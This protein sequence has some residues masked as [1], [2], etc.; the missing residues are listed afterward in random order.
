MRYQKGKEL[1]T[2]TLLL[3]NSAT[4]E[5]VGADRVNVKA[6]LKE[7]FRLELHNEIRKLATAEATVRTSGV[8]QYQGLEKVDGEFY[9]IRKNAKEYLGIRP[10]QPTT[11]SDTVRVLLQIA[12]IM[13]VY[14][15]Q[16]VVL[17]G[18]S[19]GQLQLSPAPA[20]KVLLQDPP[21]INHL[22]K[23]L[24]G[25]YEYS[26]PVEVIKGQAWGVKADV[27]SWGELA[28]R[29]LTGEA[30]FAAAQPE[31]RSAKVI[32]GMVIDP[33]NIQP[34]LS[35]A[36]SRLISACL[37]V[38]PQRRPTTGE[39]LHELDTLV[40]QK[41]CLAATEEVALF[42]EKAALYRKR[43][44]SQERFRLWWRKQG[45]TWCGIVGAIVILGLT[46]FA[47]R[48]T[49]LSPRTTPDTVI[50]YY[51]KAIRTVN[52]S[53]LDETIHR[54][55]NDL[56]DIISNIHV[57]N[58]S[59]KA[60]EMRLNGA[61][62]IKIEIEGLSLNKEQATAAMVVYQAKYKIKFVMAGEIEYLSREDRFKLT[63]VRRV[64]RITK[65]DKLK[66]KRWTIK[67]KP[68]PPTSPSPAASP[69]A[70]M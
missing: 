25:D 48:E 62:A 33:R 19:P 5:T 22:A 6:N 10:Y 4:G 13:D 36:F 57:I 67:L 68:Q 47:P 15:R 3:L 34:R 55:K 18:L 39:L 26:L 54:T 45:L 65:I 21:V 2:E 56:S 66:E 24:E 70:T 30:P 51:F 59:R 42:E 12:Q 53:L 44:Q 37:A 20:D 35:E 16:E 61:D 1:S 8:I 52:V 40:S 64:W 50:N 9:L 38:E 7:G 14:H 58:T 32:A 29:L 46:I 43:Q 27:F 17:G 31:D 63:P 28:Y 23:L 69:L 49:T 11:L 41:K 60:N